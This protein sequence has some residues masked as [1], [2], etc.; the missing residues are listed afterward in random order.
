[1]A[2]AILA[3]QRANPTPYVLR[4]QQNYGP[5]GN[6][7]ILVGL[8]GVFLENVLILVGGALVV[9]SNEMDRWPHWQATIGVSRPLGFVLLRQENP[10]YTGRAP[11]PRRTSLRMEGLGSRVE[12]ARMSKCARLVS[13]DAHA[14][15]LDLTS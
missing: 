10:G 7:L 8:A 15:S 1:V 11:V 5:E 12:L 3:R 2:A 14:P 4:L 13:L 9:A 6:A